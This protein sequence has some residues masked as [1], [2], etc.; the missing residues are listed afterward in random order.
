[1]KPAG[2]FG[3]SAPNGCA[4]M[5]GMCPPCAFAPT[6]PASTGSLWKVSD[7]FK[8]SFVLEL[9]LRCRNTRVLEGLHGVLAAATS[10]T[11]FNYA[12]SR[13]PTYTLDYPR[14]RGADWPL[15]EKPVGMDVKGIWRWFDSS[16]HW[17][18]SRY[19]SHLFSLCDCE[20]LRMVANLTS[21]LLVRQKRGF[22]QIKASCGNTNWH[23]V[24]S[25]EDSEDPALMVMPGSW[26]SVSGVS[27]HRDFIGCLPVDLSKRILGLLD[28]NTLR[29]CLKVCQCWMP[30]AQE[31]LEEIKFRKLFQKE[32]RAIIEMYKSVKKVN[33]TYANVVEVPVPVAGDEDEDED[34]HSEVQKAKLFGAAYAKIK[35]KTVQMEERNVYCGAY[36]TTVLL[37]KEDSHRV[38]DYRGGA[39]MATGSKDRVACLFHVASEMKAVAV[40]TLSGHT[41]AIQAVLLCED[42]DLLVTAGRDMSIRCWSLKTGKCEML[43]NGHTGTINCLDVHADRLVSGAKD[44]WCLHTGKEFEG[45]WFQ[46]PGSVQCVRISTSLVY[47]GCS[48]G[49]VRVWD[50]E[51]ASLLR[52]IDT[53]RSS[54]TC[55]FVDERHFLFADSGGKVAAWSV[56]CDVDHCLMT[57]KHPKEVNSLTLLYLRVI[58]GCVDGKIRIFNFLTGVCLR[59]ITTETESGRLLSLH[60]HD[61]RI[62]VNTKS[63]VKLIQF[64][65]VFWDYTEARSASSS[66]TSLRKLPAVSSAGADRT[67]KM[68]HCDR[69]P[70]G[71][72]PLY[73]TRLLSVLQ[74]RKRCETPKRS[75]ALSEKATSER[76]RRRGL[77][78]PLTRDSMLL[79]V[80]AVQKALCMDEVGVNM[81]R[82]AA[83]RDSW[84]PRSSRDPPP[85]LHLGDQTRAWTAPDLHPARA[86]TCVPILKRAKAGKAIRGRDVCTAPADVA[87]RSLPDLGRAANMGASLPRISPAGPRLL[88][89]VL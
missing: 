46:H 73:H 13:S 37:E 9:L 16:P 22:L 84:G 83:L 67:Q 21:V 35:T 53:H 34:V 11:L 44:L 45:F 62:M 68:R 74:A 20:L 33:P 56:S 85:P 12:R 57:F 77:H 47:S 41:G 69:K 4:E 23:D 14:R 43:L 79:K 59:D 87:R 17:V 88:D 10:G 55:M 6:P 29:S 54:V 80:N 82:N 5:C 25:D 61:N 70:E 2:T 49:L 72:G 86:K 18:Q 48:R 26:K 89:L 58:T 52:E 27:R 50:M 75:L 31:T 60:W 42:R 40:A 7:Y 1:M 66:E 64:A 8:R 78:H 81:E 65:K 30:L 28:E 36:F 71:A 24:T 39:L 32:N 51:K 76:V 63:A 3:E 15:D 19:L 38:V